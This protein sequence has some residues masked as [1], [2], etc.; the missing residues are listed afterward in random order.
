M[1]RLSRKRLLASI[2][3]EQPR[4][5]HDTARASNGLEPLR[6]DYPL[7]CED[8]APRLGARK[9]SGRKAWRRRVL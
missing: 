8:A 6:D 2:V 1:T 5:S 3:R 7:G 4:G 9:R